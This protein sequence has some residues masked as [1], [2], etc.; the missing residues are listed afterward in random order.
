VSFQG[1]VDLLEQRLP[2]EEGYVLLTEPESVLRKALEQIGTWQ[3]VE[4]RK[5][6]SAHL[7]VKLEDVTRGQRQVLLSPHSCPAVLG[8]RSEFAGD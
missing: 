6:A 8:R 3:E 1:G 5:V 4:D 2:T 7:E